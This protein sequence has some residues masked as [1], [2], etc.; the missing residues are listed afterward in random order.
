M[1]NTFT[2]TARSALLPEKLVTFTL[3]D[4]H[5]SVAVGAPLEHVERALVGE[6]TEAEEDVQEAPQPYY[7]LKPVGV[8]LLEK[9]AHPI[10]IADVDARASGGGLTVT[11]WVRAKGLRLMPIRFAWEE[12]DNPE[13]AQR[14]AQEVHAR[15]RSAAHPGRFSG[16]MDYWASWLLLGGLMLA[17]FWPQRHQEEQEETEE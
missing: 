15:K 6:G 9:V 10:S 1:E 3:Y 12:V 7:A 4:Q 17:L 8:S 2:Y 14:F 11:L 13:G 5:V 16:V